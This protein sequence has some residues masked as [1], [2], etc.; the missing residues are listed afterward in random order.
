MDL[1]FAFRRKAKSNAP[2]VEWHRLLVQLGARQAMTATAIAQARLE[3]A[4]ATLTK[5]DPRV[6]LFG[7][8][9]GEVSIA[10]AGARFAQI[11]ETAFISG[12][13]N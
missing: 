11:E 2:Q 12:Q 13:P 1:S 6:A 7:Q 4:A 10:L 9:G 5:I 8:A 3:R